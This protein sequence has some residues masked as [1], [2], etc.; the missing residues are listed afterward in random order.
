MIV[1]VVSSSGRGAARVRV[2]IIRISRAT[3]ESMLVLRCVKC[4]W[5]VVDVVV[6]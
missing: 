4:V 1:E 2:A 5:S 6:V 3:G